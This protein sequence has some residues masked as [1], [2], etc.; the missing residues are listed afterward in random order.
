MYRYM[1]AYTHTHA[2]VSMQEDY[3]YTEHELLRMPLLN[4]AESGDVHQVQLLLD[5]GAA[6]EQRVCV[7][8]YV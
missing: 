6:I 5:H 1:Y 2:Y 3:T 8:T 7:C 4:A